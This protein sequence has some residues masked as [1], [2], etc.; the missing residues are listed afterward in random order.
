[1]NAVAQIEKN[2]LLEKLIIRTPL[3]L[4]FWD[5]GANEAVRHNL[6]VT[7][8]P[9]ESGSSAR[10]AI[11]NPSG[12]YSF[13]GLPGL[14]DWEYPRGDEKSKD[15][16]FVNKQFIIKIED[17]QNQFLTVAAVVEVPQ[18]DDRIFDDA[19]SS[20]PEGDKGFRLFSAPTRVA[21]AYL[22]VVRA[23]LWDALKGEEAAHGMLKIGIGTATWTGIADEK[24]KVAVMFPYPMDLR[25]LDASP[26][27]SRI[28]LHEQ[29]W[30]ISV[31]VFYGGA[32]MTPLPFAELPNLKNIM[33]QTQAGIYETL[34]SSLDQLH[35]TLTLGRQLVLRTSHTEKAD[36]GKLF[37]K[38]MD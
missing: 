14:R 34:S 8:W 27:S 26:P 33:A 25:S 30:H 17:P 35:E 5:H 3:G 32:D 13:H 11:K 19:I 12:I 9:R 23:Y 28:P 24:G 36:N 16:L 4:R 18:P 38:P 31:R 29:S 1:M 20:P 15:Q 2:I 22:A 21:K 10:L 7:A 37:I 6:I